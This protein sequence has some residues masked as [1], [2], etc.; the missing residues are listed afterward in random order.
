MRHEILAHIFFNSVW[1]AES[2]PSSLDI[3]S[4]TLH[5]HHHTHKARQASTF[6]ALCAVRLNISVAPIGTKPME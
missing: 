2:K 3:P 4:I 5:W 1:Y 6:T